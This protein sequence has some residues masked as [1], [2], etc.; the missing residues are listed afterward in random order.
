MRRGLAALL[1]ALLLAGA[2]IVS[3]P[4]ADAAPKTFKNC[5]AVTKVYAGGIA[6]KGVK[7]N[8]VKGKLRPFAKK[9]PVFDTALYN[10]NKKMDR[11]KDGI[12]CEA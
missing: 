6:K 1:G 10:A 8:T 4:P 9:A 3:A 2:G 11:D 5:A 12:A 7:G